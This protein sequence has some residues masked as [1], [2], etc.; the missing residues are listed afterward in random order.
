LHGKDG[1]LRVAGV[2]GVSADA[3]GYAAFALVPLAAA[4][5]VVATAR[6]E[7]ARRNNYIDNP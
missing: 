3:G 2:G 6:V 5:L 1:E 4:L 7:R